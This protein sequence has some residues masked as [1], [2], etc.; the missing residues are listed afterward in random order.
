MRNRKILFAVVVAALLATAGYGLYWGGMQHG[1]NMA[2]LVSNEPVSAT[3]DTLKSGDSN[4]KV[5]YWHDPMSPGQK[6]DKPGKSP[7]MDMQLVP[8]YADEGSDDGSVKI[9]PR[10]Q[11]NLGVRTAEVA[12]GEMTSAVVAVG[13]IAY[14]ER[15]VV[16][17]QGRS[18]GFVERVY[19]RAPFDPVRKGQALAE[20]YIPEWV[21]A[22]E[23]YLS[24]RR[25]QGKGADSIIDGAR[26]RMRLVGMTDEQIQSVTSS[27]RV[28]ARATIFAPISGVVAEL[29]LRAGMTVAAGSPMFK[30]NGVSTMWVNADIPESVTSRVRPGD[31][32]EV[33]TPALQG[34]VFKGKVS[35]ILPDVNPATRTLKARIEL[36]NPSGQLVPGMFATI[37]F[38]TSSA[39]SNVLLIP[40][41]ALI[42]TGTRS[43]VLV[44]QGDGKF[45]PAEVEIGSEANGK[46]EIRKGLVAGQKVVVSGQFLIDSEASLTGT[47]SRMSAPEGPAPVPA[48]SAPASTAHHGA[49]RIESIDKDEI[50]ISHGPIPSLQWD[51]MTMGFKL[52]ASGLPKNLAVGDNVVFEFQ[53]VKDG[54][55]EISSIK[56]PA[57][58]AGAAR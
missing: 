10:V 5:L 18:N 6:F 7:F 19:V 12:Q 53:S 14:D 20:L 29:A 56:M 8:V 50:M 49:G 13:N 34:T 38:A 25:M 15:N 51:A 41:E 36:P 44:A 9:S 16:V 57:V 35:V 45:S 33:R 48:I 46:T 37:N 3:A 54:V 4:K 1:R 52:P 43:V 21:A 26:Q 2:A 47:E 28:Q 39:R 23:E 42:Q 31:A 17:I 24:V 40:T 30:I 58:P 11:Q 32:V 55:F 22:Q 27:D